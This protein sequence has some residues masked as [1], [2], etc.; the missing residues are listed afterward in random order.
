MPSVTQERS[1][2][3]DMAL[4]LRHR[5]WGYDAPMVDVDWLVIEYD[6]REPVALVSYK[7]E[8]APGES[9]ANRTA[10]RVLA[11][12]AHLPAFEVRYSPNLAS[13]RPLALNGSARRLLPEPVAMSER[14][15]VAFLYR[16]RGRRAPDEVLA[17][18]TDTAPA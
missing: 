9:E 7:R 13:F 10:F 17:R 12:M 2:W 5:E 14:Q 4:S 16:L 8:D 6:F 3:R 15:Y 18:L 1:G 11:W